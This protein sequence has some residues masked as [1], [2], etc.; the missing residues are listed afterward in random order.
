V[1]VTWLAKANVLRHLSSSHKSFRL[2]CYFFQ[3]P[4]YLEELMDLGGGINALIQA[5]NIL[6]GTD[7]L[8]GRSARGK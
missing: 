2:F 6:E 3:V 7:H 8:H 1:V 5:A 4:K